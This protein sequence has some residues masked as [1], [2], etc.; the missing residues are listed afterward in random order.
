MVKMDNVHWTQIGIVT[1]GY[2][3]FGLSPNAEG[4]YYF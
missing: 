1:G 3:H 2:G 4:L